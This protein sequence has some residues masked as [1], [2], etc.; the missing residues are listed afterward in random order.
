MVALKDYQLSVSL[1]SISFQTK[2]ENVDAWYKLTR[3]Y[4]ANQNVTIFE[5]RKVNRGLCSQF[6]VKQ[7]VSWEYYVINF[8]TSDRTL[9]NT[10]NHRKE[11]LEKRV[12]DLE[13]VYG[14][15]LQIKGT[16]FSC[17]ASRLELTNQSETPGCSNFDVRDMVMDQNQC[18]NKNE[19]MLTIKNK[20]ELD[21]SKIGDG[22]QILNTVVNTS[23]NSN[24][25]KIQENP[26]RTIT[27][28]PLKCIETENQFQKT[29][30]IIKKYTSQ[31]D[32][33]RETVTHQ[34]KSQKEFNN[35]IEKEQMK[36]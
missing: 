34:S 21:N 36:L 15:I 23:E 20:T 7:D 33:K 16:K 8:Y 1:E 14:I 27:V 2:K 10:K 6:K 9:I 24:A 18:S 32:F 26:N 12:P 3:N 4:F 13:R 25:T 31:S 11:L 29:P 35:M 17:D 5:E 28:F 19:L 22:K 30:V